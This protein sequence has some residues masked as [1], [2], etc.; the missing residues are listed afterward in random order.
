[1]EVNKVKSFYKKLFF[2]YWDTAGPGYDRSFKNFFETAKNGI[3]DSDIEYMLFEYI[4]KDKAIKE[5]REF[6]SK[7][8]H[9]KPS[10]HSSYDFTFT[11]KIKSD[12]NENNFLVDCKVDTKNG[13]VNI[14]GDD[15]M[16]I[17]EALSNEDY[18]WEVEGE[19]VDCI[20]EYFDEE[21]R[22]KIGIRISVG[23][24]EE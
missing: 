4:G 23:S 19:V 18:G 6:L 5:V 17:D 8:H 3:R 2:K 9:I 16:S 11:T 14:Q 12:H 22:T 13:T 15:Q 21:I 7:E 10:N 24:M 1:M 20:N